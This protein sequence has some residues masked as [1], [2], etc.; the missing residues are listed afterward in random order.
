[1]ITLSRKELRLSLDRAGF[2]DDDPQVLQLYLA[3]L[4]YKERLD[5]LRRWSF[6]IP[7]RLCRAPRSGSPFR[8]AGRAV[9]TCTS[10]TGRTFQRAS[11]VEP[12]LYRWGARRC[13]TTLLAARYPWRPSGTR[14]TKFSRA[15]KN[16]K[17]WVWRARPRRSTLRVAGAQVVHIL[18]HGKVDVQQAINLEIG[19]PPLGSLR[20]EH[21]WSWQLGAGALVV[22]SACSSAASGF[23]PA[24]VRSFG[25]NIVRAGASVYLGTLAPVTTS[26]A[27]TFARAFFDARLSKGFEIPEAL[28]AARRA[29]A[30]G[31]NPT[32]KFYVVYGE[33]P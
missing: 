27:L 25:W 23:T 12:I 29:A 28:R 3:N 2:V 26:V 5:L 17:R 4:P 30:D 15:S 6:A 16:R 32:W 14:S 1:M 24:G 33:L 19:D 11:T 7:P 31:N 18:C 21:T 9:A 22:V 20:P 8:W 10:S 13:D